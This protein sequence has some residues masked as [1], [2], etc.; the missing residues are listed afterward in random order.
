M[1]VTVEKGFQG[2]TARSQ[3][4]CRGNGRTIVFRVIVD[5]EEHAEYRLKGTAIA[6]A[7]FARTVWTG[8]GDLDQ[9]YLNYQ[10]GKYKA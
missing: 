9:A 7:E 4:M 2:A 8:K 5:G 3:R 6:C 1:V 10:A